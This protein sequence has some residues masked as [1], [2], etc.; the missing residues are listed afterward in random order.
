MARTL[1]SS[2][3]PVIAVDLTEKQLADNDPLSKI[4]EIAPTR[5]MPG[6]SRPEH[7]L[8]RGF[9]RFGFC[10]YQGGSGRTGGGRFLRACSRRR[11]FM[12][13]LRASRTTSIAVVPRAAVGDRLAG[14]LAKPAGVMA[15]NDIRGRQVIEACLQAG[16]R[17]P[18]DVAVVGV[19]E[20]RLLCELA[21]PPMS[22]VVFNLE[23]AGYQAAELLD[24]L[25]AGRIQAA[26]P[27]LVE[28]MWVI[29]RR[30]T[31]VVA[32]ED[33]HVA[34]AARFIRDHCR[35]GHHGGRCRLPV[36]HL[37]ARPGN[38]LPTAPGT[39]DPPANPTDAAGLEQKAAG[40]NEPLGRKGRSNFRL[41][42]SK[43]HEQR[44]PSR[45]RHDAD[46]LPPTSAKPISVAGISQSLAG[47]ACSPWGML[48]RHLIGK[49]PIP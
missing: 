43:L 18:D 11:T 14:S 45:T 21:N 34:A 39:I 3:L 10:G 1:L 44:L 16:L 6:A 8:E 2:R 27:D 25:M 7:L 19:D 40:G 35:R 30:S 15:C 28:A 33:R 5:K 32:I 9:A 48:P 26:A 22:S 17:V 13:G 24:G 23:R 29:P 37:A 41:Q 42:Q 49:R 36:G 20:D 47:E 4:S 12:L 46:R 38:P 31:N